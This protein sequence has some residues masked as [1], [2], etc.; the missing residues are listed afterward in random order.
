VHR[1]ETVGRR[2][3]RDAARTADAETNAISCGG[4]PMAASARVM[5]VTTPK[6]RSR[7]TRWFEVALEIA[8]L[9]LGRRKRFHQG[10]RVVM[11]NAVKISWNQFHWLRFRRTAL[12]ATTISRSR[13][14]TSDARMG[15]APLLANV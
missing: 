15:F 12:S 5:A 11:R 2:V 14:S 10:S 9:Q 13:S 6:S 4:R 7:D 8:G 1:V 3:T